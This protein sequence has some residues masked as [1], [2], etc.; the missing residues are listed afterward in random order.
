MNK[1]I[2]RTVTKLKRQC[3]LYSLFR[4]EQKVLMLHVYLERRDYKPRDQP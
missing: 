1:F 2:D 4:A 3:C